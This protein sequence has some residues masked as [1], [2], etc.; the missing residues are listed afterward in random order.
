MSLVR[1]LVG[2][3]LSAFL[4]IIAYPQIEWWQLAW[5][6]L[7]PLLWVLQGKSWRSAFGCGFLF[8][9]I[10]FFGTLGWLI[11]VTYPG[12]ALLCLYLALYPAIFSSGTVYFQK[13]PLI[14]RVFVLACLWTVLEYLRANLFTGFGWCCLGHSQ[15][16]NLVLIQIA[17]IIGLYGISF[18]VVLVNVVVFETINFVCRGRLII[19]PTELK[20]LRRLQI[21]T[22]TLLVICFAYGVWTFKHFPYLPTVKVAVVQPNIPQNMKWNERYR[23]SIVQKTLRLTDVAA[24]DHPDLILW[25]ETSLPG[26]LSDQ[27]ALV[28]QI[29]L[30]ARDLKTPIVMGAVVQEGSRYYNSAVLIG[31]DGIIQGQ[32]KKIHLVPFGEFLPLRPI[33]GW[34]NRYI[35]MEDFTSG[36]EYTLFPILHPVHQFAVLIC[37]EDTLNDLWRNFTRAGGELVMNITNDAWFMDT[38]EPFLHLQEAVLECVQNKRALVRAANTGVSGFVDPLGRIIRLAQNSKGKRTFVSTTAVADVPLNRGRT[39]YTKYADIFTQACF[40]CILW[41]MGYVKTLNRV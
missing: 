30:K 28:E 6:A 29:K 12:A 32:Y 36:T 13:L 23:P 16:K 14:P 20:Y 22:L 24:G 21:V 15:Y 9:F 7:V 35:G 18:L 38:K 39:F 1:S 33:L 40:V 26:V 8:G 17:D 25:P 10:F 41:G 2:C 3:I 5:V 19:A 27:P 4:L 11:Y 31:K 37:F 34:V